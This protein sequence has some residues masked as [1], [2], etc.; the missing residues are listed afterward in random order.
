MPSNGCAI[1]KK[2]REIFTILSARIP[3]SKPSVISFY[4]NRLE[5]MISN[6]GF[7]A[8]AKIIRTQK[9]KSSVML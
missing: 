9:N 7:Y 8:T 2:V 1:A 5:S 3:N 6:V 4:I